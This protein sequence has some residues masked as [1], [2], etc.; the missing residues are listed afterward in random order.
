MASAPSVRE[1]RMA[2][3]DLYEAFFRST[4]DEEWNAGAYTWGY[5]IEPGFNPK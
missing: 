3:A 5:W 2:Q 1:D 4:L